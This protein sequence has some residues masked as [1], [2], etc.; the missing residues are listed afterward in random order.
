MAP[1][2]NPDIAALPLYRLGF[3]DGKDV[4]LAVALN[5]V[6]AYGLDEEQRAAR[7]DP[8]NPTHAHCATVLRH[9]GDQLGGTFRQETT[10]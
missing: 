5:L 1:N 3:A 6:V 7:T 4:G 10:R 9:I 8:P 2:L